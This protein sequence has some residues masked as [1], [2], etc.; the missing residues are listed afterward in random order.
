ML[1]SGH[2]RSKDHGE[3]EYRVGVVAVDMVDD[4]LSTLVSGFVPFV[5]H[6]RVKFEVRLSIRG[7]KMSRRFVK[8]ERQNR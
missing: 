2:I 7:V 1:V 5:C 4:A 6:V 3:Q 8:V